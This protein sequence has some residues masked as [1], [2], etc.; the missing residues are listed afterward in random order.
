MCSM[1][2]PRC[3]CSRTSGP[4][5]AL[6]YHSRDWWLGVVRQF[7]NRAK[8]ELVTPDDFDAFVAEERRVFED[9][10]RELRRRRRP[11]R[12][13]GQPRAAARRSAAPTPASARTS[14]PR[15]KARSR[16][17]DATASK[18]PP[19]ARP[20]ARS[21]A[22]A[23]RRHPRLSTPTDQPRI[24]ALAASYVVD[25]AALEVLRLTELARRLPRV[26]GGARAPRRARLRRADRRRDQAVQDAA[27]TSCAAG[28]TSSATCWSTS[29]RTPTSP[30]SS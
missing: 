2:W 8:D 5:L 24:D 9:A 30:R 23:T 18:R 29:S 4:G 3:C 26:R 7:I 21:P 19:T 13:P 25:G 11:A 15:T 22:T 27:R 20:A 12:A 16:T 14:A 17:T 1:A 6:I 28:S 10:L